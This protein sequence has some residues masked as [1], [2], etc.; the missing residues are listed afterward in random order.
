[1]ARRFLAL[2]SLVMCLTVSLA[3]RATD[4]YAH[5]GTLCRESPGAWTGNLQYD[6]MGAFSG[7]GSAAVNAFCPVISELTANYVYGIELNYCANSTTLNEISMVV[8]WY[9]WSGA[10]IYTTGGGGLR[11]WLQ[12]R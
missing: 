2:V 9:D 1:M 6:Q 7:G 8:N 4:I 11:Y 5:H 10:L 3:A 12:L